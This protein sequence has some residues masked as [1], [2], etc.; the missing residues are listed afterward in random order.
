MYPIPSIPSIG[1]RL[2]VSW[3]RR[4]SSGIPATAYRTP[5]GSDAYKTPDGS[6]FY[7][8]P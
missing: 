3:F 5:D 8:T 4:A 2:G 6:A 7:L 1:L